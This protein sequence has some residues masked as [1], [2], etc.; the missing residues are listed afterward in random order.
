MSDQIDYETGQEPR[1]LAIRSPEHR[2]STQIS[3][4]SPGGYESA[5][6]FAAT[7]IESG[8]LPK[9]VNTPAKALAIIQTG[10]ELGIPP[11]T[12]LRSIY[13]V[14]GKPTLSAELMIERF[15]ARGG[16]IRWEISTDKVATVFLKAANGDEH[17][18]TFTIEEANRAGISG[19]D[20]W[21]KYP[22]QML[23][24]RAVTAA[25][26]AIGETFGTTELDEGCMVV[27]SEMAYATNG[28]GHA[29][30]SVDQV[31]IRQLREV[32]R[33]TD[34]ADALRTVTSS[35][36]NESLIVREDPFLKQAL[37]TRENELRLASATSV[38]I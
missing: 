35:L 32:V 27:E 37:R 24:A 13:I 33:E 10:Q 2:R 18:E 1:E 6:R 14:D 4:M 5:I 36:C 29:S 38:N 20:T 28:N 26:R 25:L 30:E 16:K 22:K 21:K 23:R 31:R 8:F 9:G 17:T 7:L 15:R 34:S 3:L 12:A 11:M 19:K